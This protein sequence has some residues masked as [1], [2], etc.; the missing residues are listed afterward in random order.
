MS[1]HSL[2][3]SFEKKMQ[4][5]LNSL[6]KDLSTIRTGRAHSSMLDLIKV[7]VYGQMLPINQVAT[8]SVPE[9]RL[10]SIQVW[11]KSNI[12]LIESAIQKS[13]LGINPQVE[14]Q[15]LRLRIPD[16]TEERNENG[17]LLR[18][19]HFKISKAQTRAHKGYR[20]P[21]TKTAVNRF[22]AKE[23]AE[24]YFGEQD[25]T[26]QWELLHL[27]RYAWFG[28]KS[29]TVGNVLI[30]T[31]KTNAQQVIAE[32]AI[33]LIAQTFGEATVNDMIVQ[34]MGNTLCI[35]SVRYEILLPNSAQIFSINIDH[36]DQQ[37]PANELIYQY[38]REYA[39]AVLNSKPTDKNKKAA[40]ELL[41]LSVKKIAEL[42]AARE[43]SKKRRHLTPATETPFS[44]EHGKP[45]FD[46]IDVGMTA[47]ALSFSP[48]PKAPVAKTSTTFDFPPVADA[49]RAALV[50]GAVPVTPVH[51]EAR[52]EIAA[53]T[54]T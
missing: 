21:A 6:I 27:K 2:L 51:H 26:Y 52:K 14:G 30:G 50:F 40:G 15:L 23:Y 8:I 53:G 11:D 10:I 42:Q 32:Q 46:P 37:R 41:E 25:G 43:K 44:P 38:T 54:S 29:Q 49:A 5:S 20:F 34:L 18:T 28:G 13:E 48:E 33:D 17:Y 35:N 22:T 45:R 4:D 36:R 24:C 7:E 19:G 39:L 3:I 31:D 47:K 9:A 1:T 16:L 12:A